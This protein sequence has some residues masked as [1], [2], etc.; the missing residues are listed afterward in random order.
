M[1]N[2]VLSS[3]DTIKM[4]NSLNDELQYIKNLKDTLF[5][6][7]GF[8]SS[9]IELPSTEEISASTEEQSASVENIVKSMDE[10]EK[11]L[12]IVYLNYFNHNL[13]KK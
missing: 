6:S 11:I 3:D 13:D 2:I 8:L 12:L 9:S 7:M 5:K 4:I 1:K 10:I